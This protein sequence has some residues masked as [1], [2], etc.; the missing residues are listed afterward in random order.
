M[1]A[2]SIALFFGILIFSFSVRAE[3]PSIYEII[4]NE[5]EDTFSDMVALGYDIDQRDR[6]GYT[7]LMIASS[8][9]KVNFAQ[10][11]INNGAD[12]N[13]R[14]YTG[15]TALHRAAQEG[16]NDVIAVLLMGD[17]NINIPDMHGFTPLMV[18]VI[19]NQRFTVEFLVKRGA[20]INYK[21]VDGDTAL[22]FAD[23]KKFYNIST[24][25]REHGGTY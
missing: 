18:A 11:L 13:A 6:D 10:L 20:Y 22:K 8:L 16:R 23:R 24:F 21:N 25:L 1:F 19:A 7:P 17:A 15:L 2:K 9:G 14:S 5:D 3:E 4:K 12:V